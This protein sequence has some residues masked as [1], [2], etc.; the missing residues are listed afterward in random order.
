MLVNERLAAGTYVTD[1]D[2]SGFSS[3]V[4]FYNM[5]AG[6]FTETKRMLLIK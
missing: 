6:K 1:W 2:A 5:S 4:Y 3:G